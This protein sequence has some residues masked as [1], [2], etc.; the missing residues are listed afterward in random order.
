M[1]NDLKFLRTATQRPAK[2]LVEAVQQIYPKYDKALQS[3]CENSE[4]YGISLNHDAMAKLYET[5][6]PDILEA[7]RKSRHGKHRLK[8]R[9]AARLE[10]PVYEEL[11]QLVKADGYN[12]IQD[13]L[14]EVVTAY[15][16]DK[17]EQNV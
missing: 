7:R 10:T 1:E 15:I 8:C 4:A 6:A 16:A 12:T 9:I 5:F 17:E 2:E 13:W 11:Q 3:K 14:T